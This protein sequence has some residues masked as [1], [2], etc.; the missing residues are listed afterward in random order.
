MDKTEIRT[1]YGVSILY[2]DPLTLTPV[3]LKNAMTECF[4]VSSND[5]SRYVGGV[6]IIFTAIISLI[7]SQGFNRILGVNARYIPILMILIGIYILYKAYNKNR[8][9]K[10]TDQCI[11]E[12]LIFVKQ[13]YMASQRDVKVYRK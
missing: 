9:V 2:K 6:G 10:T 12:T 5:K 1:A 3:E 7:S 13:N 11:S 8:T 4:G